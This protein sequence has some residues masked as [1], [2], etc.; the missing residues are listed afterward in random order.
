VTNFLNKNN[1]VLED[2]FLCEYVNEVSGDISSE[3]CKKYCINWLNDSSQ[4]RC[5]K[6][7]GKDNIDTCYTNWFKNPT[8]EN[9]QKVLDHLKKALKKLIGI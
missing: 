4:T 8:T 6:M 5:T 7:F 1:E 3:D 2:C 9:T